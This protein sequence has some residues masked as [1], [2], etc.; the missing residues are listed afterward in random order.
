MSGCAGNATCGGVE[1]LLSYGEYCRVDSVNG[2]SQCRCPSCPPVLRPTCGSD[3]R[4][5]GSECELRRQA[6]L[7]RKHISVLYVARCGS[8]ILHELSGR[9]TTLKVSSHK[10]VKLVD[11]YSAFIVGAHSRRSGM[12]HTVLPANYTIPASTS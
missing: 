10:K 1:C 4:T 2:L 6:C 12:D 5:Y 8:Y 11:L 9:C 7:S 3:G